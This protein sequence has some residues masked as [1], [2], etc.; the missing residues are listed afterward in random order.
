M[1]EIN[2]S[3]G[4]GRSV[5]YE[6]TGL[7]KN[8]GYVY[9]LLFLGGVLKVGKTVNPARRIRTY[10]ED[11]SL[12]GGGVRECWISPPHEAFG[13]TEELLISQCSKLGT[14]AAGKNEYFVGC[15]YAVV[16]AGMQ[17]LTYL[18]ED[19]FY[20][21]RRMPYSMVK[22]F[23]R[24]RRASDRLA[25]ARPSLVEIIAES[26]IFLPHVGIP[27][28]PLTGIDVAYECAAQALT[29]QAIALRRDRRQFVTI[30]SK[31]IAA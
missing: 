29:E 3:I 9:V 20:D 12:Y 7:G 21:L 24:R 10:V 14:P 8:E 6:K 30:D 1:T 18:R 4:G 23:V 19:A 22:E 15:D 16:L 13:S 26:L 28:A 17:R 5:A 11:A 27:E 25:A 31:E 2:I